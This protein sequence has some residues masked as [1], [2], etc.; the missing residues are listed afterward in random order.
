MTF[1]AP[2]IESLQKPCVF[3][4]PNAEL[5]QGS[6]IQERRTL[7]YDRGHSKCFVFIRNIS[8]PSVFGSFFA[9][10][11]ENVGF[12]I[13]LIGMLRLNGIGQG[14]GEFWGIRLY[15]LCPEV[16]CL[17][18]LLLWATPVVS[19]EIE[20]QTWGYLAMRP[21]GRCEVILGKYLTAVI[22]S[23]S[24]TLVSVTACVALLGAR[25]GFKL[26]VVMCLL[27]VISSLAHAALYLLIGVLFHRRTIVTAVFYTGAVEYGLSFVPAV[28]NKLTINYRLRGLLSNWMDWEAVRSR[29][30]N[31]FGS[32][33]SS[34]HLGVLMLMTV[35]LLG[36]A[37]AK[38]MFS[39]FP[40]QQEG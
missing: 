13:V 32:E 5:R 14:A 3:E 30:E 34:I 27:C 19:T 4:G 37:I 35:T 7:E 24:A 2:R 15:F 11:S 40:T 28:A 21:S 33:P 36:L 20:G 25:G 12:P 22:W 39:Q 31:V 29:A 6:L 1:E 9:A 10:D 17:L 18:A 8:F 26:W 38:V 16:L 23:V